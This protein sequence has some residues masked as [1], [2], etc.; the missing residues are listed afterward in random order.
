MKALLPTDHKTWTHPFYGRFVVLGYD[1]C[2]GLVRYVLALAVIVAHFNFVFGSEIPF[3][4][5]Y[6]AV[7]GFFALSGFLLY[8]SFMRDGSVKKYAIKR[9]KRLFPP[10]IF[11]VLGCAFL[12]VFASS[13]P[14]GR[15]FGSTA[16]M[17]YVVSNL[18]FLNFLQ[19][20]LPGVFT[21]APIPA[22]NGSLWTM[23]VEIMLYVTMPMVLWLANWFYVHIRRHKSTALFILIYLFSATYSLIFTL[24]FQK[25]GNQMY[26]ILG[27][28]FLGQLMY[29]YSGVFIYF[30]YEAFLRLLKPILLFSIALYLALGFV[31]YLAIVLMP[32][33]ISCLVI[34][35]S[36][37]RVCSV[38]NKNNISYSIY[39]FHF[40]VIQLFYQYRDAIGVPVGV[41]FLLVVA[42]VVVLS[43]FSWFCIEKPVT[44]GR[45]KPKPIK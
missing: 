5:R 4:I 30:K 38:F 42:A 37:F 1:N 15:Y 24:L 25:T 39:L 2:M 35:I 27:R 40:P 3:F 34:G 21:S 9:A 6:E 7:G 14:A 13:L 43:F 33:T 12:L 19:P 8:G 22:V 36:S 41:S 17:K 11:I 29:F 23:K 45:A 18:S 44:R 26:E 16:W 20:W 10:Y 32:L 28:Q 31:P